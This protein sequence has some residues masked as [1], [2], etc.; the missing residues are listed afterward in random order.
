[1]VWFEK[2]EL[3]FNGTVSLHSR[4]NEQSYLNIPQEHWNSVHRPYLVLFL[5]VLS[6]TD[7]MEKVSIAIFPS[8]Y[9][10]YSLQHSF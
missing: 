7:K 2:N 8:F 5:F 1:M 3:D 6:P 10:L 4:P 9:F